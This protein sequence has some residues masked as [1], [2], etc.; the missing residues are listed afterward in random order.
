[1]K[2][3]LLLILLFASVS[4]FAQQKNKRPEI[5]IVADFHQDSLVHASG[6]S[7]LVESISRCFSPKAVTDQ[8]FEENLLA[9]KKLKTPLF[10]VNVFIPG[11]LK[12]VGPD[13][14]ETAVLDYANVILERCSRA[15]VTFV[16]FG[17][18]GARRIPDGF[19]RAT[20]RQQFVSIS[21]KLG[22]L[23]RKHSVTIVL[24]NLNSTETNFITTA[25]EALSIVKDVD[26]PNFRLC[27][28]IY[29]MLKE[30][31]PASVVEDTKRYI[32]HCD[33][34]EK[35]NRTPPGTKGDDFRPYLAALKKIGYQGKIILECRWDNLALQAKSARETLLKQ[36]DDV[37]GKK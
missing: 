29:H 26:H 21:K 19:D 13:V 27:V 36:M 20:A 34:A 32:A 33:I 8:Q 23:A 18:G 9:L 30:N 3:V 5:G 11:E 14:N 28:D 17:S 4:V 1:M 22:D 31:E 35:E 7:V 37:Y 16:V 10:A 12:L 2:N 15:G 6:Y 24:E 25:T